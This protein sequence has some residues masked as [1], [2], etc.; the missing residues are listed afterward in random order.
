M[1][2][3][4]VTVKKTL[5]TLDTN[6]LPADELIARASGLPFEFCVVSVTNR[7]VEGTVLAE[8]SSTALAE[9]RT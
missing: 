6:V 9:R 3:R 7:E 4:E 8:N 2:D 5:V 1:G